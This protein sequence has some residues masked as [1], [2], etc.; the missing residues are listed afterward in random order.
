MV[1]CDKQTELN[2]IHLE[3]FMRDWIDQDASQTTDKGPR[4][5]EG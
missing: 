3:K 5:I 1:N 2:R 4:S